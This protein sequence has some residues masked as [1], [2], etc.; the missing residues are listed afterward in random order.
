MLVKSLL[1]DDCGLS[2]MEMSV[3]MYCINPNCQFQRVFDCDEEHEMYECPRCGSPLETD[4]EI[5][6]DEGLDLIDP[7]SPYYGSDPDE[8]RF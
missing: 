2:E 7:E 5:L 3:V 8:L 4:Q 1:G 6:G